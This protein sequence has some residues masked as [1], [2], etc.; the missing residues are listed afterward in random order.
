MICVVS[1]I[2]EIGNGIKLTLENG[3]NVCIEDYGYYFLS[4][5][6]NTYDNKRIINI[7]AR[8]ISE[9]SQIS[10]ETIKS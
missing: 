4:E 6:A 9:L 3:N 7:Y 8:F 1:K 5:S 10:E 2:E